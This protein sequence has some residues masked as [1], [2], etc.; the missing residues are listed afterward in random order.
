MFCMQNIAV[1]ALK[2]N[3]KRETINR[4]KNESAINRVYLL[5]LSPQERAILFPILLKC[6][7][8]P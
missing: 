5:L 8:R 7:I 1:F 6:F 2:V 4:A 3:I